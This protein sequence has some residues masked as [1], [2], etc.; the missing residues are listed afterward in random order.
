MTRDRLGEI[1]RIGHTIHGTET[2]IVV[3]RSRSAFGGHGAVHDVLV[4]ES[5]IFWPGSM[6]AFEEPPDMAWEQL[7]DRKRL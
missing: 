3:A 2:T 5:T 1:W 7:S 6:H 4:V